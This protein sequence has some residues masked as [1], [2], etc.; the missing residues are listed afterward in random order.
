MPDS[1]DQP[2]PEIA[3]EDLIRRL[4]DAE[5]AV[6][7][8]LEG[9]VD[10]IMLSDGKPYLLHQAREALS[11]ALDLQSRLA[12]VVE[13]S[14]D[15]IYSLDIDGNIITWNAQAEA[16]FGYSASEIIGQHVSILLGHDEANEND[17]ILDRI[18]Q[19]QRVDHSETI[20]RHKDGTT[21]WVSLS[22]SPLR[23]ASGELIGFSKI[24]RNITARKEGEAAL[25]MR[26]Q[27]LEKISQ[28]VLIAGA[29][30]VVVYANAGFERLTGYR[31]A[32][33]IG[34][35]CRF[36]QGPRSDPET[37]SAIRT[38]LRTGEIFDGEILNYRKDGTPFWN[39]LTVTP[40][41]NDQGEIQQFIAIQRDVT[42]RRNAAEKSR[43][44][45]RRLSKTLE[46]ITDAFLLL[47]PSWR[48]IYVNQ[49]AER[50]L[51]R[52]RV[53]VIGKIFWDQFPEAAD[54]AFGRSCHLAIEEKRPLNFEHYYEPFER[55]FGIRAFPTDEGLAIYFRDI[56]T[57][58][59]KAEAARLATER[60]ELAAQASRVGIWDFD[61]ATSRLTWDDA[62]YVHYGLPPTAG[63][64]VYDDWATALHPD[65]RAR[66]EAELAAPLAVGGQPFDTEFRIIRRND[67]QIRFIRAIATVLRDDE[68]NPWRM[69]G[70]N[71]DVTE[72][73]KREQAL[74]HALA[75]QKDLTR[76]AQAGEEA[77]SQFLAVMSHEIRTP[78]NGI[79]G[80]AA[81]VA[82]D[83][84][85]SAEGREY[86]KTVTTSGE[87]LLRIVDGILD[88]SRI[89]AGKM[90]LAESPYNPRELLRGV[91]ALFTHSAH[92]KNLEFGTSVDQ[93]VK[94][95]LVG[96]D[97]RIR[98]ILVN[99]T[100]NALK[101]TQHGSV[102]I[103][104][105][106]SNPAGCIEFR[107][108]DTGPGIPLEKLNLVFEPFTQ[109]DS[110]IS[111]RHGG[112]G[113]GLTISR[114]LAEL[115]GGSL[116]ATNRATGGAEF[117]LRIPTKSADHVPEPSLPTEPP[118]L[119]S[120]FAREH[121][122][123]ILVV[124]D[125]KINLKL[126]LTMLRKLGYDP[127]T[128]MDGRE[129]V[130]VYEREHPDFVLMDIQMP[131]MDGITATRL[132]REI[133]SEKNLSPTFI[134][135]LTANTVP[136]DQHR[137]FEAGANQFL[138]KPVRR[139]AVADTLRQAFESRTT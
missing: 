32:D 10:A 50:I 103:T 121:P 49:E 67:G 134:S 86:L 95:H 4:T 55:W 80:F 89:E 40:I 98:Q 33:V 112:T 96:D 58:H 91:E 66:A 36:L 93:D 42:E 135:V 46:S 114:R 31:A 37:I 108:T 73:R 118:A 104:L 13:A 12:A 127:L 29:D 7:S 107:V 38:A 27:A 92:N 82:D 85:L 3:I 43:R 133:E 61:Y 48:T 47:D 124:E 136:E 72:E 16:T 57:Q 123:Q 59:E 125:D 15:A 79:L 128:A 78:M 53:D 81:I 65:D 119:D 22:V 99:L 45:A 113:L 111:R 30:Q 106:P 24:A 77:K 1:P 44:M 84:T 71:W 11:R 120:D 115:M 88:F 2:A 18:R 100:A 109:A 26:N 122:S 39:D 52:R 6:Q 8:S 76:A 105:K 130:Q 28:G 69:V 139:Q 14:N 63:T 60:L 75:Q 54:S 70:T 51:Q 101:F 20:R 25:A 97:G 17:Q 64:L 132:I 41:R 137:C 56:T 62:M 83:P 34:E 5:A 117:L 74:S 68:G 19:G 35:N 23:S 94:E 116:T 87:A 129:A 90:Q 9:E 126:I 110:T 138:N 21:I 131:E 102:H